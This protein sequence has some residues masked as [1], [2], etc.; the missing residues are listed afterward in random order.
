MRRGA[1]NIPVATEAALERLR[2]NKGLASFET[3]TV[4][5]PVEIVSNSETIIR[6]MLDVVPTAEP[7]PW[8][9]KQLLVA[10]GKPTVAAVLLF[11]DEPQAALPKRSAIKIYRYKTTEAAGSREN[12][13][14]D[15]FTIEGSL[16]GQIQ[17][18]VSTT[19][20]L[21]EEV[22][23]LTADGLEAVEYPLET[24]HEIITNAVLHRDYEIA[25]DVHV[26]I[27]RQSGRSREPWA[28]SS[29]YNA[30][31]YS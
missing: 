10:D 28:P 23:V 5:V 18:A 31:K 2:R 6:F 17:A 26:R 24:L 16:Y 11:S 13:A 15:P 27:F 30:S 3:A 14:F 29:P 22:R 8:L 20:R 19:V 25:D 21:I 12:L 4:A 1:Q 7:L 9:R